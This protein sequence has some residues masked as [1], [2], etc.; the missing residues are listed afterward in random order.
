MKMHALSAGRLRMRK[1]TYLP[2]AD[3]SETIELPVSAFLLRHPQGNL[4]FDTGCHPS[5]ATDA[6]GRWGGLARFMT[7]IAPP[8]DNLIDNLACIGI[9]PDDVDVVV[10]SHLHPDHCGCN[11]FFRKA[12]FLA[13]RDEVAAAEAE[14]AEGQGYLPLDWMPPSPYR[15]FDGQYD[16]FGDGRIVLVPVPGHTPGMTGARI[17]LERDGTFFLASD[18]AALKVH[19]DREFAPKNTWNV[20]AA[21]TSLAEIKRLENAGATVLCGH[22]DA[23]WQTLR[24]GADAYE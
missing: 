20:D 2:D 23:Q 11:S 3:K 17:A 14:G 10:C 5:V 4:L 21:V 22:D 6:A 7:P 12:T 16:V 9:T 8:G 24:K 19:L 15:T 18:S 13:H 1:A